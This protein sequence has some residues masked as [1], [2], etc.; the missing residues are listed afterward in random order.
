[1]R[2][3]LRLYGNPAILWTLARM[4]IWAI[5]GAI[6]F[7]LGRWWLRWSGMEADFARAR[8]VMQRRFAEL[9][10]LRPL[11]DREH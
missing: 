6:D 7:D 8:E 2:D 5:L 1:M 11:P 10:S 9:D 3:F 4:R